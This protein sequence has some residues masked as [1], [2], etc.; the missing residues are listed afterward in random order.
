MGPVLVNTRYARRQMTGV[1]RVAAEIVAHL[2]VEHRAV[3]E[4][5]GQAAR[6]HLGEQ[7][8]PLLHPAMCSQV[9]WSPANTG[10]V[11]HPR[12]VV[13]IHDAATIRHPEF[14]SRRFRLVYR[15][16]L[17]SLGRTAKVVVVPSEFTA[18]ELVDL[19]IV[20]PTKLVVIRN[21]TD[22]LAQA[23]S[24]VQPERTLLLPDEYLLTVGSLDPRKNLARLVAAYERARMARSMPPLLIAGGRGSAFSS[25]PTTHA[26]GVRYL[27]RV[28]DHQLARLYADARAVLNVSVY[29]GFGLTVA[30]AARFDVPLLVSDIPAHRELLG[31]DDG[32]QWVDPTDV[33]AIAD[34]LSRLQGS[35]RTAHHIK[36]HTWAEAG[37]AYGDLF[38]SVGGRQ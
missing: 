9:L 21:G 22:G 24:G 12:H 19:R 8:F 16:L 38:A 13:T 3:G 25:D 14:F 11:L 20:D 27:G 29:E 37:A 30:E 5:W 1:E 6:G 7:M 32:V 35:A 2:T 17:R 15:R 36:G 33:E 26:A 23:P 18:N 31:N 10:P 4:D 34:G 28:S